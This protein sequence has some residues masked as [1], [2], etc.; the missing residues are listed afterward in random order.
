MIHS[1]TNGKPSAGPRVWRICF[2]CLVAALF[3]LA[4]WQR[5]ALPLDPIAD[6]D[7][8]GYLAPA[9]RS[10]LG[11]EFGHTYGRNFVYPGFVL[12]LLRGFGDFRAIV[13]AQHLLGLMAGG[14]LLLTWRRA[15]ALVRH[16]KLGHEIHGGLG[17]ILTA[18]F[19][20]SGEQ[21]LF[22]I[23]LRPEGVAAFLIGLT[24][25]LSLQFIICCFLEKRA[26]ATVG[27]GIGTVFSVLLLVSAKPS[28]RFVA[29][30]TLLPIAIFFFRHG[31]FRQKMALAIGGLSCAV[32]LLLPEYYLSRD[33]EATRTF[34]PTQ[35]FV[36]HADLIRD[37][38]ADDLQRGAKTPY[39]RELLDRVHHELVIEL[40]RSIESHP[41]H[42][43]SLGFCPDYLMY[44][45]GSINA[46]LRDT[47]ETSDSRSAFYRYC[48]LR[49][50][51]E[52]PWQVIRRI[53][54]Q[55]ALFYARTCPA[56]KRDRFL[57]LTSGYQDGI[58]SLNVQPYPELWMSYPPAVLYFN[59][60][61]LL[62]RSAPSIH[63]AAPLRL[64]LSLLARLYRPLLLITIVGGVV[65][66]LRRR[67]RDALSWLAA[68]VAS[69]YLW[70]LA[71]CLEV[72]I[73]HSLDVPRYNTIQMLFTMLAQFSAFWFLC[74]IALELWTVVA[75]PARGR[76]HT[77][78]V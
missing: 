3:V 63:Q 73:I 8:W 66:F 60:T 37:Q 18:I 16:A 39:P 75:N 26:A 41:V 77:Q 30:V 49:I 46:K 57:N 5:F 24:L 58:T 69:L 62:G 50:W 11:A 15:R 25:Y 45:P 64:V 53:G 65:C 7:T 17:L 19:L 21:I 10:L 4:A 42:F 61:E 54:R 40:G 6:P 29:A 76:F 47:F 20:F 32:V 13:I 70:N 9:L 27:F 48:Y 44:E 68:W 52:R 74:E 34:L 55:M 28:F 1:A 51:R 71:C 33:D 36:M 78:E 59:R 35:L 38:L 72:A 56:Y 31:W 14:I 67:C 2:W 22:E 43:R 12:W 23:E